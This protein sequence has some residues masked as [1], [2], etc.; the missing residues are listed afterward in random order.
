MPASPGA[1]LAALVAGNGNWAAFTQAHPNEDAVRRKCVF[2]HGQSPFAAII[3]CSDSRVPPELV[4]DQG[5]GDLFVARVAGN[6]STGTLAESLYY[7][8]S[9]L[10]AG[11]LFVLG[12]SD[13]GA[14]KEAVAS[15]PKGHKLEFVRLIYPAI[16]AAR[17]IVGPP[18]AFDAVVTETIKQNVILGVRNLRVSPVFKPMVDNGTLLVAGGVYDLGTYLVTIVIQ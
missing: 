11:L 8:T 1:A 7:G 3:S 9:H 16:V 13:C 14:V 17:K 18:Y 6:G 12:H 15:F 5:I 10:C 2:N 4:F